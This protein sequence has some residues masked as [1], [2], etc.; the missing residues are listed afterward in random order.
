MNDYVIQGIGF[1]AAFIFIISFQI[2]SNKTLFVFQA[3]GSALFCLQF[4]LMDQ[5]T[6]SFSLILS[7]SRNVILTQYE[8]ASWA[9][10][11]GWVWILCA[12]SVTITIFTWKGPI[13]LLPFAAFVASTIT[14]WTNN[15]RYIRL[16]NLV[17]ACPSWLTY[18]IIVGSWG[19]VLNESVMMLSIIISIIRFGW[20]NLGENFES[21]K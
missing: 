11:K 13:S 12:L 8:K 16:G 3:I 6:G 19:G 10:W 21:E 7:L 15:A 17:C 14:Y 4:F 20:K 9:R 2:K 1:I 18:D 5:L